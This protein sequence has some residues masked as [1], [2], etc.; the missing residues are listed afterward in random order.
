MRLSSV[1][2]LFCHATLALMLLTVEAYGQAE[3]NSG[4]DAQWKAV[5]AIAAG[6]GVQVH[7]MKK[8]TVS[9]NIVSSTDTAVT[10]STKAGEVTTARSDI[11]EVKVKRSKTTKTVINTGIGAGAGVATATILDGALTDGNGVS[12]SAVAF[13][14][15]IGAGVGFLTALGPS[16][17]TIYKV[18]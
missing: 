18:R 5:Q 1:A 16:Y 2:R 11:K 10:V 7:L 4:L 12:G 14:A 13:F 17:K 6:E 8:G 15:A 9:G 3:K